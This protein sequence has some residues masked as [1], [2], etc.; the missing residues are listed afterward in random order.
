[1]AIGLPTADPDIRMP[2]LLHQF[3]LVLFAYCIG[4]AAQVVTMTLVQV[5]GTRLP[6][7]DESPPPQ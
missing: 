6:H 7:S 1:M 3:G 2:P 5:T 4:V